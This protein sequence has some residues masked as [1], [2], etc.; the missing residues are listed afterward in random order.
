MLRWHPRNVWM[1]WSTYTRSYLHCLLM[2]ERNGS[3]QS[4]CPL[5]SPVKKNQP[6]TTVQ[7]A[8]KP[9]RDA[10]EFLNSRSAVLNPLFNK[11][12][13]RPWRLSWYSRNCEGL[14]TKGKLGLCH[15]SLLICFIV[16]CRFFGSYVGHAPSTVGMS[17]ECHSFILQK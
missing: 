9:V 14:H 8:N 4:V 13:S 15:P 12:V 17:S 16:Q 10:P 6:A 5:N 7:S 1:Q 2:C 11:P 3:L